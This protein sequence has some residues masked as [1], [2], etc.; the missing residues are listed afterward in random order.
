MLHGRDGSEI[1]RS[2]QPEPTTKRPL[3]PVVPKQHGATGVLRR[4]T[5]T[6]ISC[7]GSLTTRV[8]VMGRVYLSYLRRA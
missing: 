4:Y 5:H 2:P 1:A 7:L 3:H 8:M 6:E